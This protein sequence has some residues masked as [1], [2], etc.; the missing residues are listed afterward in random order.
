[1]KL[2]KTAVQLMRV[3]LLLRS[4]EEFCRAFEDQCGR[5]PI[6]PKKGR[7]ILKRQYADTNK[8][9]NRIGALTCT[10]GTI[11]VSAHTHTTLLRRHPS[12]TNTSAARSTSSSFQDAGGG[13]ERKGDHL[14]L[15]SST[16]G[17]CL[18]KIKTSKPGAAAPLLPS[19]STSKLAC[20][21]P[22]R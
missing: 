20:H 18:D 3:C 7:R 14:C 12:G 16:L 6:R 13:Q 8:Q 9:T 19:S 21:T 1:M 11:D 22:I 2:S 4:R 17:F 15:L 5:N 10:H